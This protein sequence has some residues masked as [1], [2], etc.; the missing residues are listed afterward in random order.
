MQGRNV[1]F[2]GKYDLFTIYLIPGVTIFLAP[3]TAGPVPTCLSWA[4]APATSCCLRCGG[5]ATGIY[6]CVYVRYLFH[7]GRYRNPGGRTLMY[8]AAAFLLMAVMIPYMPEEYPLKADLH[9][10]LAFFFTCASGL[11]HH[12]LPPLSQL[13]CDRMRFRR[14]WGILWMMAAC[15]VLFL[16]EAGLY[17]QFSEIFIITGLCGYLRYM[18][19]L[20]AA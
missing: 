1:R 10:L 11:Q 14:A 7:I 9:V 16:L 2:Q 17:H 19:Q 3:L 20:L 13:P 4:T 8:T 15:S 18:E 6:Y 5:F 12:W